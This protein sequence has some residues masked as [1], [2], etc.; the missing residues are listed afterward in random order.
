MMGQLSVANVFFFYFFSLS[1]YFRSFG[2]FVMEKFKCSV[3]AAYI[4]VR[5]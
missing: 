4:P 2:Y 3:K 1:F 5:V